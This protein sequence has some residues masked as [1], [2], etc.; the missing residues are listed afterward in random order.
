MS[1][2]ARISDYGLIGNCRS[3]A[4][5]SK[6]GSID[7][8][9]IPE[10][11][12]PAIFSAILDTE[13]GGTFSLHPAGKFSA[14]QKYLSHTNVLETTFET[15]EGVVRITDFFVAMEE[16]DKLAELFPDH[17]ILRIVEGLSGSMKMKLDY[18]PTMYYGKRRAKLKNY[19][20]LGL[21]FYD[22]ENICVLQC[23]LPEL[24]PDHANETAEA[25]FEIK[26]G[27][28]E[29]FSLSCSTQHPAILPEIATTASKRL[30]Q[31]VEYWRN[32]A[33]KCKYD[34]MYKEEVLRSAL[35]LKLMTHAPSGAIVAA[36]SCSLPEDTG[37]VRNWD[38]R[39][40]WLRD[41][42][43]TV[44]ALIKLGYYEEAHAYM[45]WV[46]H[47]TR[48]TRP[49]LQVMYNVFGLAE[50]K[51]KKLPWLDGYKGSRPVRTGNAAHSQFQLDVYGEVLDAVNT[52][53]KIVDNFDDA[54]RRFIIGLGK[55]ICETWKEKDDGI[56]EIRSA[57]VHHTHSKVMA[58]VGLDRL[59]RLCKKYGWEDAPLGYFEQTK[60]HIANAVEANG[61]KE[62]VQ[63]YV[64]DFE[65]NDPGTALLTLSLVG[66][67]DPNS[68]R[69]LST[70]ELVVDK[71]CRNG[72]VYRYLGTDDG[73]PG[74]E[75]AFIVGNFWLI[76]NFAK[77]GRIDEAIKLFDH[78]IQS[79]PAT[80]L[81]S[82]EID[83][84]TMEW[85]GNYPQA[86]SHIGLINAALSINEGLVIKE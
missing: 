22:R 66:Y 29:I 43:F 24:T 26:E 75:G 54:T 77:T 40:C 71:L 23:T 36:P 57:R 28:R 59:I 85:L 64:N 86:F 12:S 42:S 30:R 19:K 72:F 32:W 34:G 11:H 4:L 79:A 83:P 33:A 35:A 49:R 9:C 68:A 53:A 25:T 21:H 31:T 65:H 18:R 27:D 48:L 41:A 7:W 5:V 3:A 16:R 47:A 13:R 73:L 1:E 63:S 58:W 17:E 37:G 10:F 69:M 51:E 61:Y 50:L 74:N 56:W 84:A 38:Y 14:S 44:R 8:C 20:K 62:E 2:F 60:Q 55:T 78:T 80:M 81:L 70:I 67:C 6:Y 52:Y 15:E 46:L 76:E 45:S 82:E 39:Y